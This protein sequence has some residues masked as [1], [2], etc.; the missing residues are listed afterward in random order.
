[1]EMTTPRKQDVE[2]VVIRKMS[3][4]R[5]VLWKVLHFKCQKCHQI[6][7]IAEVVG[8]EFP[9]DNGEP[10]QEIWYQDCLNE[11]VTLW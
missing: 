3:E 8:V 6:K 2:T 7:P 4:S 11:R 1:M 5:E 10:R 9:P